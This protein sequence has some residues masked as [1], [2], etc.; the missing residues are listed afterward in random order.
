MDILLQFV[1]MCE[2]FAQSGGV[3][4]PQDFRIWVQREG[5]M[6]WADVT[7]N[8]NSFVGDAKELIM[9]ELH[10]DGPPD[11]VTLWTEG[12]EQLSDRGLVCNQ[13]VQDV[14]VIVKVAH[15]ESAGVY[16]LVRSPSFML[17]NY[18]ILL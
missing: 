3:P 14:S 7:I 6:G 17:V 9:A 1:V 16:E 5:N 8:E 2:P 18:F 10:I 15:T 12:G 11:E 13:L 4:G